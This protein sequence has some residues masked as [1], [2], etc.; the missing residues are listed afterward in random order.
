MLPNKFWKEK[1]TKGKSKRGKFVVSVSTDLLPGRDGMSDR[2]PTHHPFELF[3]FRASHKC[4]P[5]VD[6]PRSKKRRTFHRFPNAK[7]ISLLREGKG[8]AIVQKRERGEK[9]GNFSARGHHLVCLKVHQS[10][11][12]VN[13]C[14]F[15]P[16]IF[17]VPPTVR[18]DG[19]SP[20]SPML[21]AKIEPFLR[22]SRFVGAI[23]RPVQKTGPRGGFD[24]RQEGRARSNLPGNGEKSRITNCEK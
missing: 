10:I 2:P 1:M 15:P 11:H 24:G 3:L 21:Q 18:G 22:P 5:L 19:V 14:P 6:P 4:V 23:S 12:Y 9:L 13:F 16:P 20:T 17:T 8:S 7:K